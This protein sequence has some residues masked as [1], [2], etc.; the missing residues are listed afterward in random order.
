VDRSP[1]PNQAFYDELW[2]RED[3][4]LSRHERDR[5]ALI[6]RLAQHLPRPNGLILDAGC[7]T[8][9]LSAR[10]RAL[11][12]VTAI[13]WSSGG[14][15]IARGRVPGVRFEQ[16]DLVRE[17]LAGLRGR[18]GLTVSSEV[19]E[20]V[21]REHRSRAVRAL[22]TTL[23]AGG[24]LILTTPN[25]TTARGLRD[26]GALYQPD[27]DLLE[28]EE[29][30]SLV[31][32]AGLDVRETRTATFLERAWEKSPFFRRVRTSLPG[33]LA[34]WDIVDRV[35]STSR[36]GLYFVVVARRS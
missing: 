23:G 11:G 6:L 29:T 27:D 17:E 20:H 19:L 16:H 28:P 34:G 12:E 13:D 25:A 10:L 15:A 36:R 31:S 2:T 33:R 21:G 24:F 5:F 18:F 4:E 1:H 30:L 32:E 22:A 26:L 8:G 3:E 35:L 14:L 7:G 9:K